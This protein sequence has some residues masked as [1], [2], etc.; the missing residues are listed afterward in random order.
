MPIKRVYIVSQVHDLAVEV[1]S[2]VKY[3][4]TAFVLSCSDVFLLD[5][6]RS[7]FSIFPLEF[8]DP[9][10]THRERLGVETRR[11]RYHFRGLT[12]SRRKIGTARS[13]TW[14]ERKQF[15]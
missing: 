11:S 5:Y 13:L 8:V 10:K 12:N 6:E 7:L 3:H 1:T 14:K 15:F 2:I 4:I 9:R